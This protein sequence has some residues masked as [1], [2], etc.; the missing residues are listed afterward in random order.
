MVVFVI[1]TQEKLTEFHSQKFTS[2]LFSFWFSDDFMNY[3]FKFY[4]NKK[5]SIYC[6]RIP[7]IVSV[8]IIGSVRSNLGLVLVIFPAGVALL[9]RS[10]SLVV[11]ESQRVTSFTNQHL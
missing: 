4:D 10:S 7:T 1:A 9:G 6:G 11:T 3:S 8:L 5:V 2:F